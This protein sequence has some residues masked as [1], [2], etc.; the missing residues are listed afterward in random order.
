[1][2]NRVEALVLADLQ[3]LDGHVGQDARPSAGR[4]SARCDSDSDL[5]S[6]SSSLSRIVTSVPPVKSMLYI[7]WPRAKKATRPSDDHDQRAGHAVVPRADEVDVGLVHHLQHRQLLE[8]ALAGS[9]N[10]KITR[11]TKTAVNRF[12]SMP[13]I[14]VRA[15]PLTSSVPDRVEHDGR[16][17][18]GDVRVEDRHPG[19]VEPVADLLGQAGPA[20]LLLA[21][22]LEDQHVGVDGHADRQGQARPGRAARRSPA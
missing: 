7:D 15:K 1:M 6:G 14:M 9:Q 12:Q 3:A 22:P 10:S 8:P 2:L 16:E 18:V 13:M 5:T 17:Q 11:E 4:S 21:H 20:L 19:A